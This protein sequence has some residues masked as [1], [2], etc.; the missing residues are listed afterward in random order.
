M[1]DSLRPALGNGFEYE[2]DAS[3]QDVLCAE[4][5][6]INSRREK[7]RSPVDTD[8]LFGLALSGGG[9]RAAA[10]SMGVISGLRLSGVLERVEY[11]STVSGGGF[12]GAALSWY[13]HNYVEFAHLRNRCFPD[14]EKLDV[15]RIDWLPFVGGRHSG[16]RITP[17][18]TDPIHYFRLHGDYL[19][20]TADLGIFAVVWVL[21]RNIL[22][23]VAG[24]F[25]L[26]SVI[27]FIV[28]TAS[29]LLFN[30]I[31]TA[32]F[33]LF[34]SAQANWGVSRLDD[35]IAG[36]STI[37]IC[38]WAAFFTQCAVYGLKTNHLSSKEFADPESATSKSKMSSAT[39]F[40]RFRLRQQVFGARWLALLLLSTG[41]YFVLSI[42]RAIDTP[43]ASYSKS[44]GFVSNILSSLGDA[45]SIEGLPSLTIVPFALLTVAAAAA[46][47]ALEFLRSDVD[48]I[49]TAG[50]FRRLRIYLWVGLLTIAPAMAAAGTSELAYTYLAVAMIRGGT[51]WLLT[52]VV[53]LMLAAAIGVCYWTDANHSGLHR[54]YRDRLMEAFLPPLDAFT[55]ERWRPATGAN[56][57][58]LSE[59]G[60]SM[61]DLLT[62]MP[63]PILNA[64]LVLVDSEAPTFRGR[65]GDNFMFSPLYCGAEAIAWR[66]TT[67][68]PYSTITLAT[69]MA[70]SGAAINS[71]AAP[72][73][74]GVTRNRLVSALLAATNL[75]LGFWLS[76][77]K[78]TNQNKA[79]VRASILKLGLMQLM[80]LAGNERDGELLELTDGGHFD[81]TG[82]YELFRR[83]TGVII[84]VDAGLDPSSSFGDLSN[85]FERARLDFGVHVRF[86]PSHAISVRMNSQNQR[87]SSL[88]ADP[89]HSERGFYIGRIDYP[90]SKTGWLV[91]IKP[92][93]VDGLPMELNSFARLHPTFPHHSTSDQFFDESKFDAYRELGYR[94]SK[95]AMFECLDPAGPLPGVIPTAL[96]RWDVIK[97]RLEDK[98]PRSP[99]LKV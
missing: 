58:R 23:G 29:S 36:I 82:L 97:D 9:V 69:A 92:T 64:N 75:R 76:S 50:L 19:R 15:K 78:V 99:V 45:S 85:A 33:W 48:E 96:T 13:A 5:D 17:G 90:R 25:A 31:P 67:K 72:A 61:G 52:A 32:I 42:S 71:R 26:L 16:K 98:P 49:Q 38:L 59:I 81:N 88:P 83:G 66:K 6:W 7:E 24:Y 95:L 73:G 20:P 41:A 57:T 8:N 18:W 60:Q 53:L 51:W 11:L 34:Q 86:L 56:E 55:N 46:G 91:V 10:F 12:A 44:S 79:S 22:V 28:L 65:G 27:L 30:S 84:V 39:L 77:P 1:T 80:G 43:I 68:P 93:M 40:Y 3:F 14:S 94:L 2:A 54:M 35:A 21:L 4:I 63:Y 70:I 74:R 37:C 62:G 47:L 87:N 89:F